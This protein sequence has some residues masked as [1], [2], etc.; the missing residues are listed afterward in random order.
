MDD[1]LDFHGEFWENLLDSEPPKADNSSTGGLT[2]AAADYLGVCPIRWMPEFSKA[3]K[4]LYA[5]SQ[6][7]KIRNYH[8]TNR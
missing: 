8:F 7:R 2:Y 4:E 3:K 6:N 5:L 1:M